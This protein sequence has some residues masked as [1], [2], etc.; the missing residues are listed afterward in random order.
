ML[1]LRS[2]ASAL[3]RRVDR[4][5]VD[6]N[7]AVVA[8]VVGGQQGVVDEFDPVG[9]LPQLGDQAAHRLSDDGI[10]L[11]STAPSGRVAEGDE[12]VVERVPVRLQRLAAAVSVL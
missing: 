5:G 12:R 3:Q 4:D 9:D 8:C 10:A 11:R 7:E 6:R 1:M 2:A